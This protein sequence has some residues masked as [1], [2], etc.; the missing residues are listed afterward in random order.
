MRFKDVQEWDPLRSKLDIYSKIYAYLCKNMGLDQNW[1][2]MHRG[3]RGV[4][5]R[6]LDF[7]R[8]S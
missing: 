2:F 6:T 3:K 1:I 5:V 4:G 7:L 8:T